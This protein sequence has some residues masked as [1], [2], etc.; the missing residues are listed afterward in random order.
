MSWSPSRGK[1]DQS[2]AT[3]VPRWRIDI[4][5]RETQCRHQLRLVGGPVRDRHRPC[6][7][8]SLKMHVHWVATIGMGEKVICFILRTTPGIWWLQEG[9]GR[10]RWKYIW[11]LWT[12]KSQCSTNWG[13]RLTPKWAQLWRKK[14]KS[15]FTKPSS[16]SGSQGAIKAIG[17]HSILGRLLKREAKKAYKR[18]NWAQKKL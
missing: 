10:K 15:H 7:W 12:S 9:S 1:L 18:S 6:L 2:P 11:H 17:W 5:A 14:V 13:W 16:S 3:W 4:R 8:I